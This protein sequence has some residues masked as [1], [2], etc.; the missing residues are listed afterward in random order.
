MFCL[1]FFQAFWGS[2]TYAFLL[3]TNCQRFNLPNYHANLSCIFQYSG[4][5]NIW[6]NLGHPLGLIFKVLGE[7]RLSLWV[8]MD[9]DQTFG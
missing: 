4:H 7:K 3:G 8:G 1:C 6:R 9:N 5:L 2:G